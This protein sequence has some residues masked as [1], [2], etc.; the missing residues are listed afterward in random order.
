MGRKALPALTRLPWEIARSYYRRILPEKDCPKHGYRLY[1]RPLLAS[2]SRSGTN[3]LRFIIEDISGLPTPGKACLH[4]QHDGNFVIDRAHKAYACMQRH[5]KVMLVLRDYRECL[6]RHHR[7]LWLRNPIVNEFLVDRSEEQPAR[8][9]IENIEAFDEYPRE[10][11]LL[12]YEDLVIKPETIIPRLS[13]FLGLNP[14]RTADFIDRL[15]AKA[16]QS[17]GIY[18]ASGRLSVT[19]ASRDLRH[20]AHEH[21]SAAQQLEFDTFYR[22]RYSNLF[23]KY[24]K[25]YAPSVA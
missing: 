16:A 9:Y 6:L 3:W 2:Y 14:E 23:E 13:E 19:G 7:S 24:L 1:D 12:Y 18:A 8:W 25:R 22:E 17:V 15:D 10:K 5:P 21:L 11:L 4:A 20:H